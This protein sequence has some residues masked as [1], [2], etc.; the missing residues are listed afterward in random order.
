MPSCLGSIG[1]GKDSIIDVKRPAILFVGAG[2]GQAAMQT[3][4]GLTG[5]EGVILDVSLSSL[6]YGKM[7]AQKMNIEGM[8]WRHG[9]LLQLGEPGLGSIGL[10][11]ESFDVVEAV[12]VLGELE[13]VSRGVAALKKMVKPGGV[14]HLGFGTT[15]VEERVKYARKI[16]ETNGYEANVD[17]VRSFR[18]HV[19]RLP[20]DDKVR[21][22]L[23]SSFEFY[24]VIGCQKLGFGNENR[25]FD[26]GNTVSWSLL[27]Q[28]IAESGFDFL[29]ADASPVK[30]SQYQA[31]F[32]GQRETLEGWEALGTE[33]DEVFT[34]WV[35]AKY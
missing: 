17:G 34:F 22:T 14:L 26:G 1:V 21:E 25:V 9:D 33:G 18:E 23:T 20:H 19:L 13:D 2:T 8:D 12:D 4:S 27:K 15:L 5:A 10:K 30:L 16:V 6:A 35:H 11:R 7:M 29:R 32:P 3:L 31:R 28:A 24:S